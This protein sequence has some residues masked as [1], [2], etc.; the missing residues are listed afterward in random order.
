VSVSAVRP[1]I[2]VEPS[3]NPNAILGSVPFA[4]ASAT[5]IIPADVVPPDATGILVFIWATLAGDNASLAYW[6]AAVNVDGGGQ[7]WFSLLI[8][9]DAAG[10]TTVNSQ[11]F[12]LPA[13]TDGLLTVSLHLNDLTSPLN[14]GQVEIHGYYPALP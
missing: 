10:N 8:A 7:N 3:T 13:P 2:A 4:R 1:W 9:A 12:W 11:E 14:Q 6:H 5:F